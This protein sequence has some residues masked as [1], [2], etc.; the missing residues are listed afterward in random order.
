MKK[1]TQQLSCFSQ[2]KKGAEDMR[3]Q[4]TKAQVKKKPKQKQKQG[5]QDNT[6]ALS[7]LPHPVINQPAPT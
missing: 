1:Q 6:H 3:E 2:L 4:R 5:L 7:P